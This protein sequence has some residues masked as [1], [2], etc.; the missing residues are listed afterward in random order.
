MEGK[1]AWKL[2]LAGAITGGIAAGSTLHCYRYWSKWWKDSLPQDHGAPRQPKLISMSQALDDDILGEQFTRNRQFFGRTGQEHVL[3]AFVVVVGLGVSL[4][5][6]IKPALP[7]E[8]QA[9]FSLEAPWLP[10]L[11]GV[12]SHAAHM[13]L[14]AGVG[15]LRLIDF[16]QVTPRLHS[17]NVPVPCMQAHEGPMR[18]S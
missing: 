6:C 2:F 14:R 8:R 10:E 3:N 15:R 11:Q 13:L 9:C 5:T 17:A 18:V 12:G 7:L 16:D 4:P 1:Q